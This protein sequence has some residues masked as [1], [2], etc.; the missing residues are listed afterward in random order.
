ML[1]DFKCDL[2]GEIREVRV[3][4]SELDAHTETCSRGHLMRRL[5]SGWMGRI[6]W[7]GRF[8]GHGRS[9]ELG[10]LGLG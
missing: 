2:D 3:S 1:Y 4:L 8:Y 9:D 7:E 5:F 6:Q 10:P